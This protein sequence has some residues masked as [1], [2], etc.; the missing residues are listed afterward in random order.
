[1]KMTLQLKTKPFDLSIVIPIYNEEENIIPL[2]E[3]IDKVLDKKYYYEIIFVDDGSTDK[4]KEL[5]QNIM[6][7]AE[8]DRLKVLHFKINKGQTKAIMEGYNLAKA[9]I[10]VTMDG[11][12]QNDPRDIPI[13]LSKLSE[14]YD[15]VC[16]WRADRK[17][18]VSKKLLSFGS[19]LISKI[20]GGNVV[21][22][23]GCTLK[24]FNKLQIPKLNLFGESHRFIPLI[25]KNEGYNITEV[26]VKHHKRAYGKTKYGIKRLWRGFFDMLAILFWYKYSTKPLHFF[27][28]IGMSMILLSI[29][30]FSFMLIRIYL[31]LHTQMT[32]GPLLLLVAMIAIMGLQ[33]ILFGFLGELQVRTK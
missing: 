24:A 23:S 22:D 16:G 4:T 2:I 14:N 18:T 21:H 20:L 6:L 12:L 11:D 32:V 15:L 19:R 10:V 1:M 31:F 29:A 7:D 26:K 27:G 13:L 3:I 8:E 9:P 33:L 28:G 25:L 17:D 5:L 30:I